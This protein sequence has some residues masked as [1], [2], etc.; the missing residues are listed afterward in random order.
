MSIEIVIDPNVRTSRN[1]TYAGFE[2]V[3][4]GFIDDLLNGDAVTVVEEESD[5]IGEAFVDEIN[6]QKQLIYLNVQWSTL[7]PRP[8]VQAAVPP[9]GVW[10]LVRATLTSSPQSLGLGA[11]VTSSVGVDSLLSR[12]G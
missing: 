7:R 5:V 11:G 4:G 8:Q 1:R 2:D 6:E 9:T 10:A 3:R 12:A